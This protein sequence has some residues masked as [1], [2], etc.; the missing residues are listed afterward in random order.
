MILSVL[1]PADQ[2][3]DLAGILLR[4]TTTLGVRVLPV[5]RYMAER[6]LDCVDTEYG[7]VQVKLKRV[8]GELVGV[9]AEYD[10]CARL[11]YSHDIPVRRVVE[12]AQ[13]AAYIKFLKENQ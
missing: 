5:H 4:E 2:A 6:S 9:K 12:A 8:E 11:A 13:S 7:P 10:A 3:E 1:G